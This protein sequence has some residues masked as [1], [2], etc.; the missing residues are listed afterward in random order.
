MPGF[1]QDDDRRRE[2]TTLEPWTPL[3][4]WWS[5]TRPGAELTA[6]QVLQAAQDASIDLPEGKECTAHA[7][8][9]YLSHRC[10]G[11]FGPCQL[12]R[13]GT[14][15]S[16]KVLWK[17]TPVDPTGGAGAAELTRQHRQDL[18]TNT[19]RTESSD[20][21]TLSVL[22]VLPVLNPDLYARENSD[23]HIIDDLHARRDAY[24]SAESDS[25][26]AT[27]AVR[28]SCELNAV[29]RLPVLVP[30]SCRG[31]PQPPHREEAQNRARL[32][33]WTDDDLN[34]VEDVWRLVDTGA[35]VLEVTDTFVRVAPYAGYVRTFWRP[36]CG[37]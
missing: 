15:R 16:R 34:H 21:A 4:L 8:G 5:E 24:G 17:M 23:A 22:P 18:G 29:D 13:Q 1:L 11:V 10:G 36:G 32:L 28:R 14:D 9:R 35:E 25:T 26:P 27:P 37:S 31:S 33:G 2:R 6:A 3:L 20:D 7:L 30:R 12:Q 19:G